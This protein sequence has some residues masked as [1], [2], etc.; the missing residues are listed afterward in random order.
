MAK[1]NLLRLERLA[2]LAAYDSVDYDRELTVVR[3]LAK[4][5]AG[6]VDGALELMAAHTRRAVP[7]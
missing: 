2:A 1:T 7:A 4:T 5:W 6:D 3:G